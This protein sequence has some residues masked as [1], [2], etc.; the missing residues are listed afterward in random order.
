M[1][2]LKVNLTD[3]LERSARSELVLP[4]FQRDYVWKPEQQRML[5]AS[6][7]VNLPIGT[8]LILEGERGDF[9]SKELCFNRR[10]E[11]TEQCTYLLDGQQRL[12]TIKNV[13]SN[14]LGFVD[15][16]SRF[17]DLHIQL[18]YRWFLDLNE[19][20]CK[21]CLGFDAL[22]FKV[23]RTVKSGVQKAP[24]LSTKEPTEILDAIKCYPLFKTK[25]LPYYQPGFKFTSSGDYDKMLEISAECVH[26]KKIPLFNFLDDDKTIIKETL[27]SLAE[28]KV[29]SLMNE[30]EEDA[31]NNYELSN[32]Y[33]GHLDSNIQKKY[34][35]QLF[36]ETARVWNTLKDRWVDDILEYFKD[37][38][39]AEL[40][41]PNIKSNE[42]SRA[43]SVFEYMNKGGTPLDTFDIM[44]AKYADVGATETLYDKLD[45]ILTEEF[46]IPSSLYDGAGSAELHYSCEHSGIYANEVLN[47]AV[48]EQFLNFLC[49]VNKINKSGEFL[50]I[51]LPYIKKEKILALSKS[52]IEES[53]EDAGKALKRAIAF[54][55]FRCGIHNYNSLSY[56]L[57]LLPIGLMLK[58]DSNWTNTTVI[59][60]IEFWYWT[61][62][63]TG[64]FREKQNQR[65]IT[66]AKELYNWID[67]GNSFEILA[68]S[69]KVFEDSNYS[70]ENTLL[71][72]NEDRSVPTAIHNGILQYVLS[73]T[74]T[75]F[76]SEGGKLR[77][78]ELS[79]NGISIQD[80]HIIPLGS[81]KDIG[82]ST[83]SLRAD[84]FH[85]LNSP[86]NR[87][88]I[89]Q[90]ANTHIS[91]FPLSKY[92]PILD[93]KVR[94]SHLLG[95]SKID[96][97]ETS[98]EY[99][100]DLLRQRFNYLKIM[101]RNELDDLVS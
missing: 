62:L 59:R 66:E 95:Y 34:K 50:E 4:N 61:A 57:M 60:K 2:F 47:K 11:P 90:K 17:D 42:L 73:N 48:K 98:Q 52:E 6:F 54:L 27:K 18:R 63:F 31:G 89:T 88:Y 12:S 69:A 40:M 9:I 43:T 33:L 56:S 94:H 32:V 45:N 46:E 24:I 15:W 25:K 67:I 36:S 20:S 75:D 5:I 7:L 38:F 49:L 72:Q 1:D 39:K 44:V 68:R 91:S 13:F 100:L 70:D 51:D 55:Q 80:H 14:S 77:A 93:E 10:V 53:L 86:L 82:E 85:V 22:N 83:K 78:W 29:K 101:M 71:L 41:V 76:S 81:S 28:W 26:D 84:K 23:N 65:A 79:K 19:D 16:A 37:L 74:P 64:R 3:L 58:E 97:I 87:T 99:M 30:V 8:F 21:E 92:L 96:K 35:S